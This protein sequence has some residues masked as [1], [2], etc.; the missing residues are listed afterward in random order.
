[1]ILLKKSGIEILRAVAERIESEHQQDQ[2]KKTAEISEDSFADASVLFFRCAAAEPGGRFVNFGAD[3]D[4]EKS[5]KSA[6]NK[7]A[8]PADEAKEGAVHESGQK[9][10]DDVTLLKQT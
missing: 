8:A 6:E 1:M 10:A 4:D 9:E 2:E 3:V 7:H 5:G